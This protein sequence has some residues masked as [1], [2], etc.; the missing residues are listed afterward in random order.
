MDTLK[1]KVDRELGIENF[2]VV[3]G[4]DAQE[5]GDRDE[6]DRRLS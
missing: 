2:L 1:D 4:Y 6:S 5:L 3:D